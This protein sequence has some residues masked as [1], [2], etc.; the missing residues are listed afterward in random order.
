[1]PHW[2]LRCAILAQCSLCSCHCFNLSL[3]CSSCPARHLM[4]QVLLHVANPELRA[5]LEALQAAPN[6]MDPLR[7]VFIVSEAELVDSQEAVTAAA[8]YSATAVLDETAGGMEVTVGVAR[9]G[10][11]KCNRCW[12]YRWAGGPVWLLKSMLCCLQHGGL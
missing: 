12:N 5:A 1:M 7:F 11:H 8:A 2:K 6:G 10:G 4:S 3:A 9:A